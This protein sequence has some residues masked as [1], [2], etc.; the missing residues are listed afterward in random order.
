MYTGKLDVL[1]DGV[2][3]NLAILGHGIHLYLLGVLDEAAH[4]YGVL[5]RYVGSEV[6]EALQLI[7]VGAYV[8]GSTGEHV[9]GTHEHGETYLLDEG[10]D[11]VHRGQCA[12]LGLVNADAVEHG[13]ELVAVLGIVDILGLRAEEAY[14]HTVEAHGKVIGDLSAG[15][16]DNA[17]GTLEL[18]DIHHTLEGELVEEEAVTHIVV[19]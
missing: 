7:L 19:G 10:V 1:T 17:H 18:D 6:E 8:H 5:L 4:H 13:R 11:I 2:G 16:Y 3:D 12:P 15:R 9:G 14:A